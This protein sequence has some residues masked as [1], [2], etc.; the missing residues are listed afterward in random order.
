M[1]KPEFIRKL[2]QSSITTDPAKAGARLRDVWKPLPRNQRNEILVLAGLKRPSIERAY[3]SGNVSAK[4]IAAMSQVLQLDPLYITGEFNE[5]R[6]YM[7]EL[8]IDFLKEL[9]YD[10]SRRNLSVARKPRTTSVEEAPLEDDFE[11]T[12]E[13]QEE[14]PPTN[15]QTIEL[16]PELI[17]K[18]NTLTEEDINTLLRSLQVQAEFCE[19]KK[20]RLISIKALLIM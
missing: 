9:K 7:D 8:L 1:F 20:N 4:I 16:N 12:F 17:E 18:L 19:E 15:N 5:A 6:P 13:E 2:K 3:K 11:E 10:V 14:A